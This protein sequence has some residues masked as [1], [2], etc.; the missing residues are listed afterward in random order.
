MPLTGKILGSAVL[1]S[2]PASIYTVPAATTTRVNR[3][4]VSNG[5]TAGTLTLEITDTSAA[6][7]RKILNAFPL[8]ANDVIV[9]F[10]L[11]LETTDIILA[12][13]ATTVDAEI[14]IF[15]YEET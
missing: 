8:P 14:M 6:V 9:E 12:S 4:N 2:T 7:T 13:A 10:D 11:I 3:V 1:T 5:A 15:G